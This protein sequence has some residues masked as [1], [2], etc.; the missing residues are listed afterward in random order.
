MRHR[1]DHVGWTVWLVRHWRGSRAKAAPP[2][3]V[4]SAHHGAGAPVLRQGVASWHRRCTAGGGRRRAEAAWIRLA[5]LITTFGGSVPHD[6]RDRSVAIVMWYGP[7]ERGNQHR[8][9]DPCRLG[10]PATAPRR[11]SAVPRRHALAQHRRAGAVMRRGHATRWRRFCP[12]SSPV[13]DEPHRPT[14]VVTTM[15]HHNSSAPLRLLLVTNGN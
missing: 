13:A 9:P 12:A 14:N 10:T 1:C 8:K 5:V 4:A 11:A 7:P 2:G 6:D 3:G 15:T